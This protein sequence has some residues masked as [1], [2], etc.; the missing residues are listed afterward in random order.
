MQP[1]LHQI[2]S[3]EL[4]MFLYLIYKF[5]SDFLCLS[6]QTQFVLFHEYT[7]TYWLVWQ[8]YEKKKHHEANELHG[9]FFAVANRKANTTIKYQSVDRSHHGGWSEL[10]DSTHTHTTHRDLILL[11]WRQL[12]ILLEHFIRLP[13]TFGTQLPIR[14]TSCVSV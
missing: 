2:N 3:V 7:W 12:Y 9:I 8:W 11:L 4:C 10:E 6:Q 5:C 13:S 14:V 1:L